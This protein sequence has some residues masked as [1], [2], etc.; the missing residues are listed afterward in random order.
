VSKN[1]VAR[2]TAR[3]ATSQKN[4]TLGQANATTMV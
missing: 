3:P 1:V 4:L 2:T